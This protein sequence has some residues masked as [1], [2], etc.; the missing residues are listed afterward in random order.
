MP[1]RPKK[2]SSLLLLA[3]F[4]LVPVYGTAAAQEAGEEGGKPS[5]EVSPGGEQA[6][7]PVVDKEQGQETAYFY[8][9]KGKIDPFK[10]FI[11]EQEEVEEEKKKRKPT[12]YLETLDLS[13]LQLIAI[14]V[15]PKG[16]YAM[17]RDSK[18]LGHVIRKGTAIGTKGGEVQEIT[19][20]EVVVQEEFKDFRGRTTLKKTTKTLSSLQ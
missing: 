15:G 7:K 6:E 8:N 19:D 17:V 9:P 14:I 16:N 3:I 20:K 1:G 5:Q 10:S 11:A 12:T 13:Q 4:V 18:G 2:L